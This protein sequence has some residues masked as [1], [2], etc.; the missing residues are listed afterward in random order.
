[1][2]SAR[3]PLWLRWTNGSE[4]A[5][6]Y[7]PTF[8]LIFKN[9]DGKKKDTSEINFYLIIISRSSTRYVSITIYSND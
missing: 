3:R 6:H 5:E 9:G 1:M 4:Y 2:S 7:F 8:D